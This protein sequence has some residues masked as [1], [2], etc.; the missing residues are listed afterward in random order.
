M[1]LFTI[2][3]STSISDDYSNRPLINIR[4]GRCS[5]H[6]PRSLTSIILDTVIQIQILF[7]NIGICM[8]IVKH[9]F[10][11]LKPKLQRSLCPPAGAGITRAQGMQQPKA[12]TLR[13]HYTL[14]MHPTHTCLNPNP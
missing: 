14:P 10:L 6:Q 1:A 13:R 8:G 4:N 5:M 11:I 2:I 3:L 12:N 9:I 7:I